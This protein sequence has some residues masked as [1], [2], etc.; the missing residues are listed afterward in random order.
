M[1]WIY[2]GFL[3]LAVVPLVQSA[4][5]WGCCIPE[6]DECFNG[7]GFDD[8][9]AFELACDDAAGTLQGEGVTDFCGGFSACTIGCCCAGT[10]VPGS[11]AINSQE[12]LLRSTSYACGLKSPGTYTFETLTPGTTCVSICSGTPD[13]GGSDGEHEVSGKVMNG[14]SPLA[15]AEVFIPLPG[16]TINDVTDASGAYAIEGVPSINGQVFAIHPACRPGQSAPLLVDGDKTGVDISLNCNLDACRHSDPAIEGL[17]LIRGTDRIGIT[18]GIEDSCQDF[19]QYEPKYCDDQFLNC[20]ALPPT[21]S[22]AILHRGAA[23]G[24]TYCYN[25][26]A[27]FADGTVTSSGSG[28]D[29]CITT[30]QQE[31]MDRPSGATSWCGMAE[32]SPAVVSCDENNLLDPIE[33]CD[34]GETCSVASG[35]PSCVPAPDC[36]RCNGL[37]GLFADL[38]LLVQIGPIEARCQDQA[39][40]YLDSGSTGNPLLV[41]TYGSCLAVSSCEQYASQAACEADKCSL[42]NGC[43]WQPIAPELGKGICLGQDRPACEE[44]DEALGYCNKEACEA[45]SPEC[46]YDG[47]PNNLASAKGCIHKEDMACRYYDTRQDCIGDGSDA[48]FDVGYSEGMRSGGTN[49]RTSASQD[50]QGIGSCAWVLSGERCIKDAD[51]KRVGNE[52]DCIENDRI[53]S[54]PG[55]LADSTPPT[56][57]FFFQDPPVYGRAAIRTLPHTAYDDRTP[58]DEIR[59]YVCFAAPGESCYPQ[60]TLDEISLPA[61][62]Q[63]VLHYYSVDASENLEVVRFQE[64]TIQDYGQASIEEV[65]VTERN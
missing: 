46:Y 29:S 60:R 43:T 27:R 63:Y 50:L 42:D 37:L 26:T 12:D 64:I 49:E 16:G 25:V 22:G 3:L 5:D 59:T 1:R 58:A 30:G 54:D 33:T 8:Q 20:Q 48:R 4:D 62:G 45:I 7:D 65:T 32:G 24:T 52:D 11:G 15:N 56:T 10:D 6:S 23:P 9:Q 40:C 39:M 38:G 35:S 2:F 17:E 53:Y 34:P 44:C 55:C 61:E 57:E 13:G 36:E 19:I 31:C 51:M 28:G 21:D 14:S 18:V 47:N 41:E